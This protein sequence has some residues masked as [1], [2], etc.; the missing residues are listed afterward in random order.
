MKKN[1]NYLYVLIVSLLIS[2]FFLTPK[3]EAVLYTNGPIVDLESINVTSKEVG[4]NER[5]YVSMKITDED[6]IDQVTMTYQS[7]WNIKKIIVLT[8]NAE[9]HLFE[10]FLRIE[11]HFDTGEWSLYEINAHNS[12]NEETKIYSNEIDNEAFQREDFSEHSFFVINTNPLSID[13]S[14]IQIS[15]NLAYEDQIDLSF[16]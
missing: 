7:K 10:G 2:M 9:S 14:S 5:V 13:F 8:Y 3:V 16:K 15:K 11:D 1:Y 4:P 6:P 12:L